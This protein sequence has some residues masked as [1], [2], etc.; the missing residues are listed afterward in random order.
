MKNS[1][2][3]LS[4]IIV[5]FSCQKKEGTKEK[6]SPKK[7]DTKDYAIVSGTIKNSTENY[8]AF[9]GKHINQT[10]DLQEDGSFLDTLKIKVVTTNGIRI[11][12]TQIPIYIK[13]GD[14]LNITA[15]ANNFPKSIVYSGIGAKENTY[16]LTQYFYGLNQAKSSEINIYELPET[17][18]KQKIKEFK[19]GLDSIDRLYQDINPNLLELTKKQNVKSI[20]FIQNLYETT[21]DKFKAQ[22]LALQKLVKGVPSPKFSNYENLQG[23]PVSLDNFKGNYVF[24]EVWGTWIK[25]YTENAKIL[26]DFKKK[27]AGKNIDFLTLCADNKA[28]SG[29]IRFAKEKWKKAIEKNNLLGN[30]LFIGND[31]QFLI[32]YQILTL[33]RYILIDPEGKI[34]DAKAPSPIKPELQ[35]LFNTLNLK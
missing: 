24:I 12:K 4:F 31:R 33:P 27:Y 35:K 22:K 6:V 18:F 13:N 25:E 11:R 28:S 10:I 7:S 32:D 20:G 16:L 2:F 15:D 21:K 34:I 29:T 5:L 17:E 8:F 14:H 1:F 23:K 9:V 30:H 26:N 19:I 3:I